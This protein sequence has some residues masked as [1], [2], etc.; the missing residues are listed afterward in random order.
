MKKILAVIL[1]LVM[2]L[3]FAACGAKPTAKF[4][5]S[6]AVNDAVLYEFEAEIEEGKTAGAM[7]EEYLTANEVDYTIYDG[8]MIGS[9]GELEQDA[10]NWSV[11]WACYYNSEYAT[12][13]LWGYVPAEGDLIEVKFEESTW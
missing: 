3:S 7:I 1:A 6:D 8:D 4:V 2:V 12:V 10:E 13:G 5:I 9:I 11:Y